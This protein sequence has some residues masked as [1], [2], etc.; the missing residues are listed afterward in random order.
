MAACAPKLVVTTD[1][2]K[3]DSASRDRKDWPTRGQDSDIKVYPARSLKQAELES[4]DNFP[5]FYAMA[6]IYKVSLCAQG[7]THAGSHSDEIR[8]VHG[9][10]DN[11]NSLPAAHHCSNLCNT[12]ASDMLSRCDRRP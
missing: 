12:Q 5:L 1:K 7:H 6:G 4:C 3:Y 8:Q 2:Y 9:L 11:R 10:L